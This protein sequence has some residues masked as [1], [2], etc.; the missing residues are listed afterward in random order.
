MMRLIWHLECSLHILRAPCSGGRA[1]GLNVCFTTISDHFFANYMNFFHRMQKTQKMQ[2]TLHQWEGA[3]KR[4][5]KPGNG[6]AFVLCHN[7]EQM[8]F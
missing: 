5:M 3:L 2:K 8:K 1:T 6:N 7:F 4:S